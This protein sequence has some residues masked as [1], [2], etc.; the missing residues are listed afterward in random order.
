MSAKFVSR[1][2]GKKNSTLLLLCVPC[3]F[4]PLLKAMNTWYAEKKKLERY[5]IEA[6]LSY[7]LIVHFVLKYI[8]QHDSRHIEK[9]DD[10]FD[11]AKAFDTPFL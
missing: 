8:C 6:Y 1:K 7:F 5:A 3:V 2:S 11:F 4:K 10:F 9:L